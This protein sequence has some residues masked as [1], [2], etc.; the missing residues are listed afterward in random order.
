MR[1]KSFQLATLAAGGCVTLGPKSGNGPLL[2]AGAADTGAGVG[3][4]AATG[5]GRVA[6]GAGAAAGLGVSGVAAT[7]VGAGAGAGALLAQPAPKA[8][9][10]SKPLHS[11]R[12]GWAD[13]KD[14]MQRTIDFLRQF[15]GYAFDTCQFFNPG[16]GHAAQP[17][18]T[19]QQT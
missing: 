12:R 9:S 19:L 14:S 13:D 16:A 7:G 18:K 10:T 17:A 8:A 5:A 4:G 15:F 11:T 3:A 6:A 2:G 1:L